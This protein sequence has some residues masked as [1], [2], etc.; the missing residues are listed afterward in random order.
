MNSLQSDDL[1]VEKVNA[2]S[3]IIQLT[4]ENNLLMRGVMLLWSWTQNEGKIDSYLNKVTYFRWLHLCIIYNIFRTYILYIFEIF[5]NLHIFYF[6]KIHIY[7]V[8]I[9]IITIPNYIVVV[10]FLPPFFLKNDNFA[11]YVT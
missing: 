9:F 7:F 3:L 4:D 11:F 1:N 6:I 5:K 8:S 10:T 2:F